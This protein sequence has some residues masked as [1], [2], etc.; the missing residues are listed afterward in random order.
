MAIA[1]EVI[2]AS[3]MPN[4]VVSVNVSVF[5]DDRVELEETFSVVGRVL[6]SGL[7]ADGTGREFPVVFQDPLDVSINDDA[8]TIGFEDIEYTVEEGGTL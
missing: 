2:A 3:T 8:I 4:G 1:E 7:I 6:E 5:S